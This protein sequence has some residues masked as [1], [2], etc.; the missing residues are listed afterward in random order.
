MVTTHELF[1]L[2]SNF[3]FPC[4]CQTKVGAIG[5]RY[6]KVSRQAGL[7]SRQRWWYVWTLQVFC[8]FVLFL[9]WTFIFCLVGIVFNFHHFTELTGEYYENGDGDDKS[10]RDGQGPHRSGRGGMMRFGGRGARGG[11]RGAARTGRGGAHPGRGG[12]DFFGPVSLLWLWI[13]FESTCHTFVRCNCISSAVLINREESSTDWVTCH[14]LCHTWG[15]SILTIA[16]MEA[17]MPQPCRNMWRSK[18]KFMNAFSFLFLKSD[19][20]SSFTSI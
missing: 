14:L 20:S 1:N 2:T 15:H 11:A 4:S 3:F 7:V 18:C 5:N 16:H 6:F 12:A 8:P 13:S 10:R 9:R 19:V 17:W